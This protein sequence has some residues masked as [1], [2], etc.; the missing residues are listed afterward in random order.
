MLQGVAPLYTFYILG[1]VTNILTRPQ[2]AHHTMKLRSICRQE[3]EGVEV[4][5]AGTCSRNTSY[6]A[7]KFLIEHVP[8][9]L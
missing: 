2:S 1:L 6:H 4:A 7:K 3:L 8:F 5:V 9:I